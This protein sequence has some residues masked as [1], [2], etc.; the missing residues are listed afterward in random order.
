MIPFYAGMNAGNRAVMVTHNTIN[1]LDKQ[2]PASLSPAVYSLLRNQIGFEGLAITDDLN[3]GAVTSYVGDGNQSLAALKAGADMALVPYPD[4]QIPPP[5][6]LH[7]M[8]WHKYILYSPR[9]PQVH[10]SY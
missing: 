7:P 5:N 9:Q 3:M 10:D 8:F 6:H 1:Y 2:N 4:K